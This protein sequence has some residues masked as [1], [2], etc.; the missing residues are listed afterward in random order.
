[1]RPSAAAA[2]AQAAA[3][4]ATATTTTNMTI[5]NEVIGCIIGKGGSKINEIR[6]VYGIDLSLNCWT[7]FLSF[8]LQTTF[9]GY[10]Q[11]W[12]C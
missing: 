10:N 8:P 9:W 1:M 12:Q 7:K 11:N 5:P 2:A 4:A 3:L 6:L